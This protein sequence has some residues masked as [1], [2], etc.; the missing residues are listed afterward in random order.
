MSEQEFSLRRARLVGL[1]RQEGFDGFLVSALANIRYLTGFTGSSAFLFL[2]A[3]SEALFTDPRYEI[4]AREQT[5]CRVRVQRGSPLTGLGRLLARRG[6]RSLAFESARVPHSTYLALEKAVPAGIRLAPTAGLVERLRAVKSPA[7]V[8]HIR[9]AARTCSAAFAET[10]RKIRPGIREWDLA[11]ELD[12]Q[13]R[14][15]GAERPAFDTIVAFGPRSALPHA[16]PSGRALRANELLLIDMGAMQAG[17]ASDMTRMVWLGRPSPRARRLHGA[18]LEAQLAALDSVRAGRA[19]GAV[20]ASARRVLRRH[21]LDDRFIHSTG[22]ALGLEIH[23]SPRLG[24]GDKT[25][26]EAGMV[27]TVEPGV[28]IENFGGV[29]IED[30]VAV[31]SSGCEILTPASKELLVL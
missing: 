30:T 13:M 28:Y 10:V 21:H 1:L 24:R 16:Q 27:V 12:H 3:E 20:D 9:N 29:R 4:Q 18:V 2:D 7:E 26:L 25:R 11:A 6:L 31:T 23:E 5:G 17:Y 22:H 14:R 19:A 8:E 15:L